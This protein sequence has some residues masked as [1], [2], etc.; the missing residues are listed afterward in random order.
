[1]SILISSIVDHVQ[2]INRGDNKAFEVEEVIDKAT[3][4]AEDKWKELHLAGDI[5]VIYIQIQ[6]GV[7]E[8]PG[9]KKSI[10]VGPY[11]PKTRSMS[12][13]IPYHRGKLDA[14]DGTLTK[15]A[16]LRDIDVVLAGVE[17]RARKK[18]LSTNIDEFKFSHA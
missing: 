10:S 4:F 18:K 9:A 12:C 7:T 8:L 6:F 17:E 11:S 2:S 5:E 16:I 13:Y 1:M 15:D 14:L 3:A